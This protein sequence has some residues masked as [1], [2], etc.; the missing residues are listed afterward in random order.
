MKKSIIYS[1]LM[2][3]FITSKAQTLKG[4]WLLGVSIGNISHTS[5]NSKTTYSNTP[6]VYDSKGSSTSFSINPTAGYFIRKNH[7]IGA[8]LSISRYVSNSKSSN[9]SSSTTSDSKSTQPSFYIGPFWRA[10]FGSNEKTLPFAQI[11]FQFGQSGGSSKSSTS[12]GASSETTTNPVADWNLGGTF[13]FEHFLSKNIGAFM[14]V[15]ANYGEIKTKY[16]YRPST[17]TGY[18]YTSSYNRLYIT[19]NI[20][21]QVHILS[22]LNK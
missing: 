3:M 9:T 19:F 1:F 16:F 13:G 7:A 5:S 15:G 18:D 2:F 21:I 10:Y 4:D 8:F 12:T 6:T 11:G 17:G 22:R 14:S 20:G